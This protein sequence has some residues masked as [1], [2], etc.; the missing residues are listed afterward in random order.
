M[1]DGGS[2]GA[3]GVATQVSGASCVDVAEADTYAGE[4][5]AYAWE[6]GACAENADSQHE[7]GVNAI[8]VVNKCTYWSIYR[9]LQLVTVND[10]YAHSSQQNTLRLTPS[11]AR[12]A[13]SER[14]R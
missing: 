8:G 6:C 3:V 14:P 5:E 13:R 9:A 11:T 4:C 12:E 2:G 10:I 7:W 1:I